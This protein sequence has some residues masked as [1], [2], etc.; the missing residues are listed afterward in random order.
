MPEVRKRAI[1]I[2]DRIIAFVKGK[3]MLGELVTDDVKEDAK[4]KKNVT[5]KGVPS[6]EP[7]NGAYNDFEAV[8]GNNAFRV[9]ISTVL[10][11]R[12]R[13]EA[14]LVATKELFS[15][16]PTPEAI[17]DAPREKIEQ[18]IRKSGMYKTKAARVQEISRIILEQ[19]AGV[20]PHDMDTLMS[21][22][23]VGRKVANCVMV[24]AFAEPAIPVDTHVHRIANRT[25]LVTTKSPEQT[26]E[27]LTKLYPRNRWLDVNEAFVLHGKQIC[28]PV[29]PLCNQCP[30]EAL[31]DKRIE[32]L[33]KKS[34]KVPKKANL[35]Q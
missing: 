10:S 3:T 7:A 17:R 27:A 19:Y 15:A 34:K 21:L 18:L 23:G 1:E 33:T 6:L 32:V 22:P 16:L 20:V 31:C 28:K 13:D 11:V 24:Y 4:S 14:T 8:T 29:G 30:I 25:G 12:N 2:L 9:L 26:E 35:E 5:D